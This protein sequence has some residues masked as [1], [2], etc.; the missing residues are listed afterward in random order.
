[1]HLYNH[2]NQRLRGRSQRGKFIGWE[3]HGADGEWFP[4]S[5]ATARRYAQKYFQGREL[6]SAL[7]W[8]FSVGAKSDA[9]VASSPWPT[10]GGPLPP[11]W[12]VEDC[13]LYFTT[14][15]ALAR[16][17]VQRWRAKR[18]NFHPVFRR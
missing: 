3:M 14:M 4:V 6:A 11:E 10:P 5:A 13:I 8:L 18:Q 9:P 15:S 16:F 2:L 17:N 1:M 7:V 12:D